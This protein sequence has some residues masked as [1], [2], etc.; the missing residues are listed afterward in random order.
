MTNQ[1][2]KNILMLVNMAQISM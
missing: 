1:T 2:D